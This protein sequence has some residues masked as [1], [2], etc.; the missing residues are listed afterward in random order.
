M[1]EAAIV[2]VMKTRKVTDFFLNFFL[3]FKLK[4]KFR[5]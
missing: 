5:N 4:H 2:R 1:V 3:L